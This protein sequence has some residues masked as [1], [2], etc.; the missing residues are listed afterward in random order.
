[1]PTASDIPLEQLMDA[2][3]YAVSDLATERER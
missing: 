2:L 3:W 1:M